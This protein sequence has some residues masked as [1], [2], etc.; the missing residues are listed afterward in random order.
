MQAPD[1]KL[2]EIQHKQFMEFLE[3]GATNVVT[4]GDV[5]KVRGCFFE[6]ENISSYGLSAKGISRREYLSKTNP[7][8]LRRGKEQ[9]K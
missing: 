1:G 9:D 4:V 5:F 6:V 3:H 8:Q 7:Q 2:V